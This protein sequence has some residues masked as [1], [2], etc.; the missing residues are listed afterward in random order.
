MTIVKK[1][2]SLDEVTELEL[3]LDGYIA[4]VH[5]ALV[6]ME[7]IDKFRYE[8][9]SN[10]TDISYESFRIIQGFVHN[11]QKHLAVPPSQCVTLEYYNNRPLKTLALESLDGM[12]NTIVEAVKATFRFIVD[13]IKAIFGISSK[14]REEKRKDSLEYLEEN[15]KEI[16]AKLIKKVDK[17]GNVSTTY[18]NNHAKRFGVAGKAV[19]AKDITNTLTTTKASLHLVKGI[20]KALEDLVKKTL[21]L[22]KGLDDKQGDSEYQSKLAE[23]S[24]QIGQLFSQLPESPTMVKPYSPFKNA[25]KVV[26]FTLVDN[27]D[28]LE[29]TQ[30]DKDKP[31]HVKFKRVTNEGLQVTT[32][33][34]LFVFKVMDSLIG[35]LKELNTEV[36]YFVAE[37]ESSNKNTQSYGEQLTTL[38]ETAAKKQG[39]DVKNNAG[40]YKVIKDISSGLMNYVTLFAAIY[41]ETDGLRVATISTLS[42]Q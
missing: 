31:T 25:D 7:S 26:A 39:A 37:V 21:D 23:V 42:N 30:D 10:K 14:Q 22:C 17:D 16:E 33:V 41:K 9:Y 27:Y 24:S 5:Q 1:P 20:P 38:L 4:G 18:K 6:T 28:V 13:C 32:E 36:G 15:Y 12:M 8:L 11:T 40:V 35:K 19:T 34:E 29:I 3:A 2:Q